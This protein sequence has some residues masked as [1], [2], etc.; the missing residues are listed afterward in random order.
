MRCMPMVDRDLTDDELAEAKERWPDADEAAQVRYKKLSIGA[1]EAHKEVVDRVTG[2]RKF[3][4]PQGGG[5]PRKNRIGASV[6]D[7][8]SNEREKDVTDAL[9]SGLDK[10]EPANVRA[11]TAKAIVDISHREAE[12]ELEEDRFDDTPRRELMQFLGP[13]LAKLSAKGELPMP[14][15]FTLGPGEAI[16]ARETV[17]VPAAADG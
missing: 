12:L 2:R 4:G 17:D 7:L 15:G 9:F 16:D 13:V 11:K 1:T 8:A 10:S 5:R 3:G 6:A 14:P